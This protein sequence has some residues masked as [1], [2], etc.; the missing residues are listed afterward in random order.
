MH[1]SMGTE[2]FLT[3]F[4]TIFAQVTENCDYFQLTAN[5]NAGPESV[6]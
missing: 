2:L 4:L 6:S 5:R 3:H 1:K